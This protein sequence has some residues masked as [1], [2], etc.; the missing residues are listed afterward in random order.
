MQ[1]TA[2]RL[3]MEDWIGWKDGAPAR[4]V[5]LHARC[6]SYQTCSFSTAPCKKSL[7]QLF[8][9]KKANNKKYMYMM[10]KPRRPAHITQSPL[11]VLPATHLS[12]ILASRISSAGIQ[13]D[14]VSHFVLNK[15]NLN[16]FGY[17]QFT[18]YCSILKIRSACTLTTKAKVS[19][20]TK[21]DNLHA[22]IY[23]LAFLVLLEGD[24]A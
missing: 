21:M 7:S 17:G 23:Y 24:I 9:N 3:L 20:C 16:Y 10:D 18:I 19:N 13:Q 4:L 6:V 15:L 11:G 12:C 2:Q 1:Q 8:Y 14:T 22:T 5:G